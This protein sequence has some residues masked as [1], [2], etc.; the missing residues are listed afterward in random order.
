MGGHSEHDGVSELP[1]AGDTVGNGARWSVRVEL[2]FMVVP[3]E[4]AQRAFVPDRV[5][6]RIVRPKAMLFR[7]AS[8]ET[9]E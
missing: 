5:R 7:W 2:K 6:V 9:V 3:E 4:L 8:W 1:A